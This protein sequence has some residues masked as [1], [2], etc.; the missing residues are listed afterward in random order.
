M[1][2]NSNFKYCSNGPS[3]GP[4]TFFYSH[5]EAFKLDTFETLYNITVKLSSNY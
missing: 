5:F 1:H 4:G 3:N 2:W